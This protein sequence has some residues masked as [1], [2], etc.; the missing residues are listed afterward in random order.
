ME[1]GTSKGCYLV[2]ANCKSRDCQYVLTWATIGDSVHY[3]LS[4]HTDGWVGVGFSEDNEVGND[5][6]IICTQSPV[7]SSSGAQ[8]R[9]M[10][11]YLKA[12]DETPGLIS[13]EDPLLGIDKNRHSA[14]YTRDHITCAFS[15]KK[16]PPDGHHREIKDLHKPHYILATFGSAAN[17]VNGM[18]NLV[19][20]AHPYVTDRRVDFNKEAN[21][22]RF[23]SGR[24]GSWL[25]KVHGSLMIIAW[26]LLASI[27]MLTSRYYRP[28]WITAPGGVERQGKYF[29]ISVYQPLILSVAVLSVIA[30]VF[31]L[32]ELNWTWPG[33]PRY[34][35][36]SILGIVVICL[37]VVNVSYIF[38]CHLQ[39]SKFVVQIGCNVLLRPTA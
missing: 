28:M 14:V 38:S 20:P 35:W 39:K 30:L 8:A 24:T 31:I 37:A 9:L 23:R 21:D 5:Q 10:N 7:R 19:H 34:L 33:I 4:A 11:T 32:F 12:G 1:C 13:V 17:M 16:S 15:R 25:A 22:P 27:A 36:H 29:W 6:F 3:E 18:P 26:V 2:P